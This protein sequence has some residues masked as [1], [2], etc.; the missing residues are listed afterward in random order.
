MSILL[1]GGGDTE[2][3]RPFAEKFVSRVRARALRSPVTVAVVAAADPRPQLGEMERLFEGLEVELLPIAVAVDAAGSVAEGVDRPRADRPRADRPRVDPDGADADGADAGGT[4]SDGADSGALLTAAGIVI[5]DGQPLAILAALHDRVPDVRRLVHEQVPFFGIGGGA[6]VASEVA[7]LG[8]IEIGGVR[9]APDIAGTN[10][11]TGEV[12]TES[13]LGL[14][15]LTVLAHAAERGRIGLAV[16]C[17][18]AGLVDRILA[19]DEG[20]A[21]EISEDG[22]E[23]LG[24]G[25]LWQVIGDAEGVTVRTSRAAPEGIE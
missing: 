5:A 25:S 6:M 24:S 22:I 9:V 8:G 23:L 15:D 3:L 1:A 13:G 2:A 12:R 10:A 19:L 14:V 11:V 20:T 4:E 7:I 16:A 18:E 21:V 17:C